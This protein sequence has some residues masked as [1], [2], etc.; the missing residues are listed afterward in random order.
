MQQHVDPADIYA[1]A[2]KRLGKLPRP[3]ACR[4]ARCRGRWP[5]PAA[6]LRD[7]EFGASTPGRIRSALPAA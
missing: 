6:E 4:R 5:S 3:G 7:E 1:R 2:L